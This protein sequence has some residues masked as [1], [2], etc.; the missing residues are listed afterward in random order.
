MRTMKIVIAIAAVLSVVA[1]AQPPASAHHDIV[2][3]GND[4]ASISSN[5]KVGFVCDKEHDG[6]RVTAHFYLED[7]NTVSFADPDGDGVDGPGHN[8][9]WQLTLSSPAVAMGVC[10]ATKGCRIDEDI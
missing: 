8:R 9:C 1:A 2:R 10:E 5:H 3:H 7:G 6:N 4:E